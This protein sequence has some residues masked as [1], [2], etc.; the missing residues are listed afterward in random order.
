MGRGAKRYRDERFEGGLTVFRRG[1]S[2]IA[3][4]RRGGELPS[5]R[6]ESLNE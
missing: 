6:V 5:A 1:F 4:C 3:D 2:G